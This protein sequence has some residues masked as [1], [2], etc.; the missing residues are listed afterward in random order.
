[1]AI[2]KSKFR[3]TMRQKIVE[4]VEYSQATFNIIMYGFYLNSEDT[5]DNFKIMYSYQ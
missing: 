1:M 5:I 4:K 3:T 2:V